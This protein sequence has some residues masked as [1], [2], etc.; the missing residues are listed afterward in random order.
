MMPK[1]KWEKK[2]ATELKSHLK[3]MGMSGTGD[4]GTLIWRIKLREKEETHGLVTAD[5]KPPTLL[6][7]AEVCITL[8]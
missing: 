4:K 3:G 5:G 1:S 2:S 6:K 8:T 7:A